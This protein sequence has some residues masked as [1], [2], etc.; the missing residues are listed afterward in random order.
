MDV[1]IIIPS[2]EYKRSKNK[3]KFFIPVSSLP[4]IVECIEKYTEIS[5]EVIIIC[6]GIAD[7]ELVSYVQ[8]KFQKYCINSLNVG[9]S[10]AWNMGRQ[11]AEGKA[12]LYASDDVVFSKGAIEKL[13][14]KLFSDEK[15]GIV[16][17]RGEMWNGTTRLS[18]VETDAEVDVISGYFFMVKANVFDLVGGFDH[19]FTPAGFEEIDFNMM[20]KK[21]GF[22]RVV[23]SGMEVKTHTCHGISSRKEAIKY[24]NSSIHTEDLHLRNKAYFENK[25]SINNHS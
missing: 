1:S 18:L 20:V 13:Y 24:L 3:I 17:P 19:H 2:R 16:G 11:M 23:V 25:W 4:D 15:I 21:A 5:H 7:K 8:N 9:V 14:E 22:K 6:N 10:R 12:L